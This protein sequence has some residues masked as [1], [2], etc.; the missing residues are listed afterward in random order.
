M[1]NWSQ[2]WS[3]QT[4]DYSG[5]GNKA[6][7]QVS[8]REIMLLIQSMMELQQQ[9][10]Q[11]Q[12]EQDEMQQAQQIQQRDFM[13]SMMMSQPS[14]PTPQVNIDGKKTIEMLMDLFK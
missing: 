6:E 14:I 12:I 1:Q 7:G 9:Q 4:V 5:F 11:N 8:D 2:N 3:P 13:D 10:K